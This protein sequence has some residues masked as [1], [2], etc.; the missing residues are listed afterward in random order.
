MGYT[1]SSLKISM[2]QG[3]LSQKG[4]LCDKFHD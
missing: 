1:H 2:A 3:D 4:N